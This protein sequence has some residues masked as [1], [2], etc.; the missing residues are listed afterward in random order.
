MP[1]LQ[2]TG[3]HAFCCTVHHY[4]AGITLPCLTVQKEG[5]N[6]S[7]RQ[8]ANFSVK[9]EF[10]VFVS[11]LFTRSFKKMSVQQFT[12]DLVDYFH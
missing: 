9:K 5:E 10:C 4:G 11:H 7:A 3:N 12:F 2:A 8:P 6:F 1:T